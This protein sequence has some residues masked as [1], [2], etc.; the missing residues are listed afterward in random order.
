MECDASMVGCGSV[1]YQEEMDENGKIKRNIIR[2]GSRKWTLTESLRHTSLEREAMAI[3]IG[4]KQHLLYLS[5]CTEAIIKTNLKSLITILRCYN[6]PESTRMAMISH[7]L[8]SL[9]FKWSLI[10]IP[11]VDLPLADCLSRLYTPYQNAYSDR[12]LRYPDLQREN[13]QMPDSWKKPDLIL[14]TED[15]LE[16]MIQHIVFVEKSSMPVKEKRLKVLMEEI[17]I[18]HERLVKDEDNLLGRVRDNLKYVQKVREAASKKKVEITP[19][20]AVSERGLV[21]PEYIIKKQ[22]E[23]EKIHNIIMTLCT[24]P[25]EKISKDMLKKYRLLNDS[26]LVTRKLMDLPFD[27]PGNIRIVCDVTM[28]LYIL[29]LP[30][31]MSCHPGMNTLNHLFRNTYKCIEANV[32]GLVKLVCTGCRVCRF[33]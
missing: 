15:I 28:S 4:V 30:H 13:I 11:G 5:A 21:T 16:V 25:R 33:H 8:Y 14:T 2:Y 7:R 9:P 23:N 3:L 10:H 22:N 20:T 12:H 32:A 1:L 6:N 19:L 31:V 24:T 27:A 18:L 26:I 17:S 29:A